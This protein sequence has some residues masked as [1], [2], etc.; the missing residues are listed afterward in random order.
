M[1]KIQILIV[2]LFIFNELVVSQKDS[3]FTISYS[4]NIRVFDILKS[5]IK[6]EKYIADKKI[7]PLNFLKTKT[8][9][10]IEFN[11]NKQGYI[12][13]KSK[14]KDWGYLVYHK[15]NTKNYIEAVKSLNLEKASLEKEKKQ[16]ENLS[17]ITNDSNSRFFEYSE[18][19][20]KLNK[21]IDE[22]DYKIKKL[23]KKHKVFNVAVSIKEE[24]NTTYNSSNWVNM[25]G[26]EY[27]FL[28]TENPL[29]NSTPEQMMG[30][31]LKYL[32]HT[33]KSYAILGLYKANNT[34]STTIDDMYVF[35]FGQ[36]F[37]SRHFGRGENKFLNLY[38]S[39]NAG[40]YI[41]SNKE[42]TLDAS[43]Y[44]NPFF[45]LELLKTK[46]ILIDSKIGYF[47]PFAT[48]KIQRGLLT[49]ISF[50]FVF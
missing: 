44:V 8:K 50:N 21:D 29:N 18:K 30:Y 24:T 16:Y 48:N 22:I 27:S 3:L 23:Y 35:G 2:L 13:L 39:F 34:D 31:N 42:R 33:G 4:A 26:L 45:G 49:N 11:T 15:E 32:F 19:I 1:K 28:K 20:I 40:V 5:Q 14:I 38:V 47:M 9:L 43:W 17:K 10:E 41:N 12:E 36:D 25:P 6:I 37:Y 7:V 46:H